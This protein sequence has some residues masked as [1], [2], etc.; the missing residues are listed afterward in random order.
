MAVPSPADTMLRHLR[1]TDAMKNFSEFRQEASML[2]ALQHPCIVSLIGISI[3]PLCFALELAPLGSLNTVLSENA[4]GTSH[5]QNSPERDC[6]GPRLARYSPSGTREPLLGSTGPREAVLWRF[7][8]PAGP[9]CLGQSTPAP[10]LTWPTPLG[11]VFPRSTPCMVLL[12]RL[13]KLRV[14]SQMQPCT[15]H[16]VN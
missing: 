7:P 11:Q 10:Q 3:H 15:L 2:H 5:T 6:L 12:A 4:R 14:W 8:P 16:P 1:A 13:E 9:G